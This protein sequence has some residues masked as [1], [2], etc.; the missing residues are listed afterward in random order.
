MSAKKVLGWDGEIAEIPLYPNCDL[1]FSLDP[2]DVTSG[3][4]SSWPSGATSTLYFYQGDPVNGGTQLTTVAGIVE[5]SSIDYV[6]QSTTL[7]PI[8]STATNFLLIVSMPESPTQEYPLFYG[9]VV[10]RNAR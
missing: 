4:L 10:K 6:I 9:K 8:R 5:A 3:V 2:V 7:D 1:V